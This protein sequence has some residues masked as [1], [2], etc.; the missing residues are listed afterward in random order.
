MSDAAAPVLSL[1]GITRQYKSGDSVLT[2][3]DG[4]DLNIAPGEIVGLIGPSGSGKS[5]LLHAAG[6]L[7]RPSG[8]RCAH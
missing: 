2:V 5:S 8:G 3:L 1:S 7:E 6:M 4:V